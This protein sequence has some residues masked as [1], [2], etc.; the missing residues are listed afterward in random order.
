MYDNR[1]ITPTAIIIK[2]IIIIIIKIIIITGNIRNTI[3]L[4]QC[5][6]I[7]IQHLKVIIFTASLDTNSAPGEK[8]PFTK[9]FSIKASKSQSNNNS[10]TYISTYLP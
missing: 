3:I 1:L 10:F 4:Y 9:S 7:A 2:I 8:S 6:S 5:L